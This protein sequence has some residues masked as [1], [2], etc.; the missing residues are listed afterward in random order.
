MCR[1]PETSATYRCKGSM[2]RWHGHNSQVSVWEPT[3]SRHGG[4][5][6]ITLDDKREVVSQ[7]SHSYALCERRTSGAGGL[8]TS[9][10][11]QGAQKGLRNVLPLAWLEAGRGKDRG[12]LCGGMVRARGTEVVACLSVGRAEG[13]ENGQRKD[14]CRGEGCWDTGLEFIEKPFL[15]ICLLV[16]LPQQNGFISRLCLSLKAT[17]LL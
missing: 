15:F 13:P 7:M 9:W 10:P 11:A 12:V 1:I 5:A 3:A 8:L 4:L 17:I 2:K 14:C 16:E 6:A